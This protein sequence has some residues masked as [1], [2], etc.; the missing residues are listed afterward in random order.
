RR[1]RGWDLLHY[2]TVRSGRIL[3]SGAKHGEHRSRI[4][5]EEN[6]GFR[7]SSTD[8]H[9]IAPAILRSHV[10]RI[11][12][13]NAHWHRLLVRPSIQT[14]CAGPGRFSRHVSGVNYP[15]RRH[16]DLVD[17]ESA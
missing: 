7:S 13:V 11:P 14:I 16:L 12:H 10:A 9:R 6:L 2:I 5:A 15:V 1:Y 8:G 4:T 17:H 3:G